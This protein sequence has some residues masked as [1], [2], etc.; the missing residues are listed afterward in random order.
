MAES[1]SN[2]LLVSCLLSLDFIGSTQSV[3]LLEKSCNV[4]EEGIFLNK[5]PHQCQKVYNES[6]NLTTVESALNLPVTDI[7]NQYEQVLCSDRCFEP[8]IA[9]MGG[10]YS[11][12]GI[13]D[14]FKGL[15]MTNENGQSCYK[16]LRLSLR[17]LTDFTTSWQSMASRFCYINYTGPAENFTIDEMCSLDCRE[18]LKL[19]I[20]DLGCCVNT[21]YNTSFVSRYLPFA[22]ND[23]WIQ[24]ELLSESPERCSGSPKISS[25]GIILVISSITLVYLYIPYA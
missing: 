1:I 21:V 12:T 23:L 10:C 17:L 8:F 19:F 14:S 9:H 7:L 18:S 24:C 4:N 22:R 2:V 6:V 20:A 3:S 25:A 11:T 16:T 15:C 5:Y 13:A